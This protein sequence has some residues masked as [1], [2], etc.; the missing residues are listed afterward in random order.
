[1]NIQYSKKKEEMRSDPLMESLMQLKQFVRQYGRQVTGVT[2]AAAVVAV[3]VIVYVQM[4]GAAESKADAA[5]G[6]ALALINDGKLDDAVVQLGEVANEYKGTPHAVYAAYALGAALVAQE[7]Y[8][9]AIGWYEV[10]SRGGSAS[11]MVPAAA[12][13][14]L[15]VAYEAKGELDK[16]REYCAKALSDK[17]LAHRRPH[18]RW[19]LALLNEALHES[20]AAATLCREIVSD[21]MAVAYHQKARNMLAEITAAGKARGTK[22]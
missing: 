8:D 18:L 4:R 6:Q 19:R 1:V 9:E 2:V 5:F 13:E 7:R 17:R 11:S 12:L 15:A 21:T 3:V 16:A 14:G 10:A 20:E 22:G